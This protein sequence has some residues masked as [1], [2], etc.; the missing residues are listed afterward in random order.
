MIFVIVL[1][2]GVIFVFFV[3]GKI[4]VLKKVMKVFMIVMMGYL[5]FLLLNL[6]F[7]WI[8]VN[9]NVFGLFS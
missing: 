5:V 1:V 4:C 6:V 3:S 8:G 2:V 7:M 9:I